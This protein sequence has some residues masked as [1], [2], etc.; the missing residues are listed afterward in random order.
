[1]SAFLVLGSSRISVTYAGLG[2]MVQMV[3]VFLYARE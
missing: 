3:Q 2:Q 1:M